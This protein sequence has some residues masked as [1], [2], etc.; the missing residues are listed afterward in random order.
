M[1]YRAHLIGGVYIE[2]VQST[3]TKYIPQIT[4]LIRGEIGE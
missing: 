2:Y 1:R 3:D 4:H